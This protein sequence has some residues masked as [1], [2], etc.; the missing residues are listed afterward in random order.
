MVAGNYPYNNMFVPAAFG[1]GAQVVGRAVH[2]PTRD[3]NLALRSMCGRC[4]LVLGPSWP[5]R[6]RFA[7]FRCFGTLTRRAEGWTMSGNIWGEGGR[8]S[9]SN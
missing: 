4:R 2:R 9:G 5:S 1:D 8:C 6:G 7:R 3:S